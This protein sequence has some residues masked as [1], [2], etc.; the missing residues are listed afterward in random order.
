MIILFFDTETT[1]L[2]DF[3]A[4][5]E[6]EHQPYLV[7]LGAILCDGETGE[8]FSS[9]DLLSMVSIEIPFEASSIHGIT[10]DITEAF[11][12]APE[13]ILIPFINLFIKADLIVGHNLEYDLS[14]ISTAVSRTLESTGLHG[15]DVK[16][17]V[18]G[19]KTFCTMLKS[20]NVC[21]IQGPRGNKW[22]K[23]IEAYRFFFNEDF[24]KAHSAISDVRACKRIYFKMKE[25]GYV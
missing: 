1:G 23:L 10:N 20:T 17:A 4:R 12:L 6:A 2:Y 24:E 14:I 16:K 9:L 3:K 19:K 15:F 22:P 25:L 5:P 18:S 11:G 21:K 7:Q 13:Q 8:E